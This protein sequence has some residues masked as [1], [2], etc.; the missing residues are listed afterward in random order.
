[1]AQKRRLSQNPRLLNISHASLE[2]EQTHP[3]SRDWDLWETQR[4]MRLIW[5][6]DVKALKTVPKVFSDLEVAVDWYVESL[7]N[8]GRVFYVGAG[9]AGRLAVVDA[10]E[11]PPTFGISPKQVLAVLAGGKKA[12]AV[13]YEG[14]EDKTTDARKIARRHRIGKKD[15]V[16]GF[17][18]S[19]ATPFVCAFLQ[20]AQKKGA[21]TIAIVHNR[22]CPLKACSHLFIYLPTGPELLTGSTRMKTGLVQKHIL[23]LLSTTAMI[24]LGRVFSHF[25]I[26]VQAKNKKLRQRALH[27]LKHLV[28]FPEKRLRRLLQQARF[29]PAIA[30]IM[31][32]KKTS[33][34]HAKKL[35]AQNRNDLRKILS[36]T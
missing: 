6:E 9:T 11:L 18:A 36:D 10:A 24:R 16:I 21:R 12:F 3:L 8:G 13:A 23:T 26:G 29:S 19:G 20:E 28:N 5:E 7:R 33:Y 17:S 15:L 14:A 4:I 22:S 30:L 32:Q 1:M 31:A 2:T 35:L 27:I 25:M 34:A